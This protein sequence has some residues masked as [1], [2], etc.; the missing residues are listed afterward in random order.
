MPISPYEI[1]VDHSHVE[2]VFETID[3]ALRDGE[4]LRNDRRGSP[5]NPHWLFVGPGELSNEEKVA[6]QKAY[7][8][9]GWSTVR[10]INSSEQ[11]ER[12]GLW[13][14]WLFKNQQ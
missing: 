10:V 9:A 13:G 5:D 6:V 14:V 1:A 8:N 2:R 3:K 4:K 7:I 11:G 12:S